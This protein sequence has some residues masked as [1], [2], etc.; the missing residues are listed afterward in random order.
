[1]K[2]CA[3]C[4]AELKDNA[5][6]CANC[7]EKCEKDTRITQVTKESALKRGKVLRGIIIALFFITGALVGVR[8]IIQIQQLPSKKDI[9]IATNNM[10]NCAE[11][12]SDGKWLYYN[13]SGLW[14]MRMEDEAKKTLIS[15]DA[16][17]EQ[18]F[19]IGG[20]LYYYS[21]LRYHVFDGVDDKELDFCHFGKGCL[22]TDGKKIYAS[23][24]F[25]FE[26]GGVYLIKDDKVEKKIANIHP[27]R[28]LL[29]GDYLYVVSRYNSINNIPNEYYG[30]W[31]LTKDGSE[32]VQV[33][34]YCPSY[35]IF[36]DDKIY[37]TDKNWTICRAKCNRGV[38]CLCRL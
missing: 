9:Q 19:C 17:A 36:D 28:L 20:K 21:K 27:T 6:F 24:E 11:L 31:R 12:A 35:L 13:N 2:Y 37:F 3:N 18:M 34:D 5:K 15:N 23:D 22:Q 4:G 14:K 7:G 32:M 33:F 10:Q 26:D 8:H 29:Q 38:Y 1:M 25:S 16:Y 30:T